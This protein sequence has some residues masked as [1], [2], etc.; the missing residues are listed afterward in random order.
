MKTGD[1]R[2]GTAAGTGKSWFSGSVL[3]GGLDNRRGFPLVSGTKA[4][5]QQAVRGW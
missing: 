1:R 4:Q 5:L 3:L 2:G